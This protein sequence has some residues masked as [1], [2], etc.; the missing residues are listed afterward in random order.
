MKTFSKVEGVGNVLVKLQES[1]KVAVG[2]VHVYSGQE[3]TDHGI[4]VR[5]GE[6]ELHLLAQGCIVGHHF[7]Q[8][9]DVVVNVVV[10]ETVE[11]DVQMASLVRLYDDGTCSGSGHPGDRLVQ[12]SPC[13]CWSISLVLYGLVL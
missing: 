3:S 1:F 10:V 2:D 7:D 4:V 8:V 5:V 13:Q 9:R 11:V 6:C 12:K